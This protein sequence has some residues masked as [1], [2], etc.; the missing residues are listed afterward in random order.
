M[1]VLILHGWGGS[2][3]P[4]WQSY[5][6]GEIAKDYGCVSFL[7]FSDVDN[8]KKDIWLN[9]LKKE[10]QE[11]KPTVVL[12][13]SI[14]NILWFH[15]CNDGFDIE[16]ERLF[17]VAPPSMNCDIKELSSFYPCKLPKKL[18]SKNS[19]LISSTND[20]YISLDETK[21]MGVELNIDIKILENAG[22]INV[23]SGYGKWEWIVEATKS[24]RA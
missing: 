6:A 5:L 16:L 14:A 13:H 2:D 7:R 21:Q 22:H 10:L 3:Y 23:D 12:C 4:H 24:K 19:L 15:L 8:P 18:L 20:P 17:L 1:R 11:F 9:E